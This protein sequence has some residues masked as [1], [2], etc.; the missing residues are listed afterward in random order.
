MLLLLGSPVESKHFWL[1]N[2]NGTTMTFFRDVLSFASPALSSSKLSS[3]EENSFL[4]HEQLNF[5]QK[6]VF[7][8]ERAFCVQ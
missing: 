5:S 4:F 1:A 8:F 2:M 7:N 6:H 3:R